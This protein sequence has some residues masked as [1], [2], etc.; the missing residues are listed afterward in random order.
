MFHL[1]IGH[2]K[3]EIS[4]GHWLRRELS[5]AANLQSTGPLWLRSPSSRAATSASSIELADGESVIGRSPECDVVLDVA[6]VSRRH[7][8]IIA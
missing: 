7:A 3:F 6:A 5:R 1:A 2:S 8:V 4:I